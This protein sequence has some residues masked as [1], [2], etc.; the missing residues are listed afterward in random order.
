MAKT[1]KSNSFRIHIHLQRES[2]FNPDIPDKYTLLYSIFLQKRSTSLIGFS[3][4][5]AY[6]MDFNSINICLILPEPHFEY[7]YSITGAFDGR[8]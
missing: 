4:S 1:I 8:V 5:Y 6:L 3:Q 2:I 7:L